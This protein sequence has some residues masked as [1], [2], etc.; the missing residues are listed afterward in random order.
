MYVYQTQYGD[1]TI[2]HFTTYRSKTP[3]WEIHNSSF[4][5]RAEAEAKM[6]DLRQEYDA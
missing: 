6:R 2:S 4:K 3:I 1:W 5:T